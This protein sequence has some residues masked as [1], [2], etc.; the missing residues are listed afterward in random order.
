MKPIILQN[1]VNNKDTVL[2]GTHILCNDG[3]W[4]MA[5]DEINQS[6]MNSL[7][8]SD[9]QLDRLLMAIETN[10]GDDVDSDRLLRFIISYCQ[11]V[12]IEPEMRQMVIDAKDPEFICRWCLFVDE[13]DDE[14]N[15]LLQ[16]LVLD[17]RDPNLTHLYF[18][19]LPEDDEEYK[20]MMQC[21]D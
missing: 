19:F 5:D 21:D 2:Y 18:V 12:A 3:F 7:Q 16:K 20:K 9:H 1:H 8:L 15:E 14:M 17:V 13:N 6:V 4:N 11:N 10:V